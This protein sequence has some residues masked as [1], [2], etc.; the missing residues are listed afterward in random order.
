MNHLASVVPGV[1]MSPS[2]GPGNEGA[3]NPAKIK[4]RVYRPAK[5]PSWTMNKLSISFWYS[6][7]AQ[8][9]PVR[10]ARY[11]A[12][13]AGPDGV[14]CR[15]E[16]RSPSQMPGLKYPATRIRVEVLWCAKRRATL[17]YCFICIS[18]LGFMRTELEASQNSRKKNWP[19]NVCTYLNFAVNICASAAGCRILCKP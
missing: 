7:L 4:R 1:M 14:L 19:K 11:L 10:S 13:R 15:W 18:Q 16:H 12:G 6:G 3:R 2:P 8:M 9:Y 5:G 17:L